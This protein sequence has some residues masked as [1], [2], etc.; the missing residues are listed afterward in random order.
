MNIFEGLE[1]YRK[2]NTLK[3]LLPNGLDYPL[4]LKLLQ[5]LNFDLC[6]INVE[7]AEEADEIPYEIIE[8][9]P[10]SVYELTD[11]ERKLLEDVCLEYIPRSI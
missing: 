3:R 5:T 11:E 2:M 7:L 1:K 6:L 4:A 9:L 8:R 10:F